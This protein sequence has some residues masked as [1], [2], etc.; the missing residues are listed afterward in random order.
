MSIPKTESLFCQGRF[1]FGVSSHS[2][3]QLLLAIVYHVHPHD[4]SLFTKFCSSRYHHHHH[5]CHWHPPPPPPR[6]VL[7]QRTVFY[8]E[9]SPCYCLV[10]SLYLDRGKCCAVEDEVLSLFCHSFFHDI[11][12]PVF[13]LHPSLPD[14]QVFTAQCSSMPGCCAMFSNALCL[15]WL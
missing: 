10:L 3:S 14:S 5:H 4:C 6:L 2:C 7:L 1:E 13:S 11:L 12:H 15:L 9:Q 8:S